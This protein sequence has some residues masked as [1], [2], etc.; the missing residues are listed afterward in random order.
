M[1]QTGAAAWRQLRGGV[2]ALLLLPMVGLAQAPE[3]APAFDAAAWSDLAQAFAQRPDVMA[4]FTESRYF[5]FKENPAVLRGEVRVSRARGLSLN[6]TSPEQRTVIVDVTGVLLR[7][8]KSTVAAPNDVRAA[9]INRAMMNTLNLNFAALAE[10]FELSGE[11]KGAAWTLM[12]RPRDKQ[13]QQAFRQ[14]TVSGQGTVVERIELR[15]SQRQFI[16]IVMNDSREV[17][18]FSA[19][20]ITRYFR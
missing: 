6:Y 5:P 14:I 12:M 13:V 2:A 19:E 7:D 9:T 8:K 4:G 17:A 3:P 10:D 20:D 1:S 15:R 11:R 18:A 16:E